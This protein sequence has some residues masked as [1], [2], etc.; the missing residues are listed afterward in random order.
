ME[1]CS[2]FH[3]FFSNEK[4]KKPNCMEAGL[5]KCIIKNSD[6]LN[7]WINKYFPET[8]HSLLKIV[9]K[10]LIEYYIDFC[11]LLKIKE[12]RIISDSLEKK[13][14]EYLSGGTQ[15]GIKI[16]YAPSK[17]GDTLKNT[18][19]KNKKF[20]NNEPLLFFENLVFVHYN[21]NI[22]NYSLANSKTANFSIFKNG[23]MGIYCITDFSNPDIANLTSYNID[24]LSIDPLDSIQ[25]YFE[26]SINLLK[27][28][29]ENYVIPG[30]GCE[31]GIY[32]GQNVEI[33]RTTKIQK[34]TAIGNNVR[35]KSP[36]IGPFAIIGSNS[37][38]DKMTKIEN[39]IVYDNTYIGSELEIT[40]KIIFKKTIID[41][42]TG[43]TLDVPDKYII[44]PLKKK[45]SNEISE[46]IFFWIIALFLAAIQC[47]FYL[48]LI[49][50]TSTTH[51]HES[52]IM[53]KDNTNVKKLHFIKK[54]K[55]TFINTLFFKFSLYKFP[56]LIDVLKGKIYLTGNEPLRK[57]GKTLIKKMENY[58]PAAFTIN[59]MLNDTNNDSFV[60]EL[61]E[62]YYSNHPNFKL[63][64]GI[65][66][67]SI[68]LNLL[69]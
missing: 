61:N 64:I 3:R 13:L 58:R 52:C 10:P 47:P 66:I 19:E 37:L 5:M 55:K 23:N 54:K 65:L 42:K 22:T 68:V 8:P 44:A 32:I 50:F 63:N 29:P 69:N 9:N 11:V 15:W 62:L 34:P 18:I 40:N 20:I 1:L 14:T 28:E 21:K 35:L 45:K 36:L 25:K 59:E 56:L 4:Q 2:H 26:I 48:L 31:N 67:K 60:K 53:S 38:I 51:N 24:N 49:T 12:I 33:T 41:P 57:K 39:A 43:E 46:R 16:T 6:N 7:L 27:N 17:Q 30:Y